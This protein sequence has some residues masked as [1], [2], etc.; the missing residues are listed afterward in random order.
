ML[1]FSSIHASDAPSTVTT[2]QNFDIPGFLISNSL[3]GVMAQR[4][5]RTICPHCKEEYKPDEELL[6]Q[7][8]AS[9]K[10]FK[11]ATFA[12]GKGCSECF[13]TGYAGRTGIFEIMETNDEIK[14]L[15][16]RQTTREVIRQVAI[17]TGMQTLKDSALTKVAAGVTTVEEYFRVVYV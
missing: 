7:M 11:G 13:H 17:D 6:K 2:L 1:V 4:L 16:F 5:V 12:R 15:V 9:A 14:D 10:K 8:G 3:I